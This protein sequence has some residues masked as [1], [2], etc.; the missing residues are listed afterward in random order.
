MRLSE[1]IRML[2]EAQYKNENRNAFV[3]DQI[4][5]FCEF[6]GFNNTAKFFSDEADGERGHAK[7]IK[8]Y[9]NDKSDIINIL[10]ASYDVAQFL[11]VQ[12]IS[13]NQDDDTSFENYFKTALA[14]EELTTQE[15]TN[16]YISAIAENDVMS[17]EI[18]LHMVADQKGEELHHQ[19][20]IDRFSIYPASPSRN[21]DIDIWIG[22]TFNA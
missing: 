20:I 11:D 15:L 3:Y 16:I 6:R 10:P 1:Q 5:N 13:V 19:S 4:A 14:L 22:E 9:I 21:H 8:D 2:L 12:R 17:A 7:H 18:M